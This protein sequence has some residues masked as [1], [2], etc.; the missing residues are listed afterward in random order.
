MAY[1][2]VREM[3]RSMSYSRNFKIPIPMRDRQRG[4]TRRNH[5]ADDPPAR[6]GIGRFKDA[7]RQACDE[8]DRAAV[9]PFE[10]Q[11]RSPSD[12]RYFGTWTASHTT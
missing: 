4:D 2:S 6:G 10:L 12:L 5:R 11:P 9:E 8:D 1:A 3:I 7:H